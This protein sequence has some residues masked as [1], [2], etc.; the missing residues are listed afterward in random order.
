[1]SKGISNIDMQNM[2]SILNPEVK[3]RVGTPEKEDIDRE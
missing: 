2:Y 1:M 3:E